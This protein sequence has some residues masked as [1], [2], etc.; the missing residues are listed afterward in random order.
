MI[1]NVMPMRGTFHLLLG[2]LV[3]DPVEQDETASETAP[4][5]VF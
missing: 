5:E 2:D 4:R 3:K 1:F